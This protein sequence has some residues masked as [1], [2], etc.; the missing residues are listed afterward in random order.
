VSIA[1]TPANAVIG[2]G[3]TQ[4]YTATGT[5]TDGTT[6]PLT[7]ATWTSGTPAT[8]TISNAAGSNGLAAAVAPGTT[9]ITAAVGAIVS[10]PVTL[11]VAGAVAY[12]VNIANS[13]VGNGSTVSQ[14]SIAPDGAAAP[15]TLTPLPGP[16]PL[17]TGPNPYS[18]A[19]DP[20]NQ[21]LYVANYTRPGDVAPGSISEFSIGVTG[22]LTAIAT[23][24]TADGPNSIVVN[25][26]GPYVYVA[27]LNSSLISQYNIG[28]VGALTPMTVPTVAAGAANN[29]CGPVSIAVNPAGTYAYAVSHNTTSL[30]YQYTISPIDGSLTP[31]ITSQVL[32]GNQS[33]WIAVDP[34]GSYVYVANDGD[35]TI[36]QYTIGAGG[37][38][39]PMA[40][41]TVPA[42]PDPVSITIDPKGRNVY[43]A[44][45]N[46]QGPGTVWQFTIGAGGALTFASTTPVDNGP[47]SVAIDPTGSFAY[48]TNRYSTTGTISQF[49]VDPAN[50]TLT[51][52]APPFVTPGPQPAA[53]ITAR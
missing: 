21:Y 33:N 17:P 49:S 12:S 41:P 47:S 1:V 40:I 34:S 18:L 20:A 4:Q 14:F 52:L 44:N 23:I 48:V 5:Y 35:N 8:A 29:C 9:Q 45:Q 27:D 50:G 43:V 19:V 7:T 39:A 28:A 10:P 2:V 22:A 38:L 30:I 26:K 53:I 42:G 13:G 6:Q 3:F 37:V 11:T 51:P 46:F 32:A 25:P 36:S 15:G 24:A 31:I 16:N